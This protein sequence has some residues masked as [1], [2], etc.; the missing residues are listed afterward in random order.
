M[1]GLI[2][3]FG[4]LATGSLARFIMLALLTGA[5]ITTLVVGTTGAFFT[6][7]DAV[8]AN[9]FSTGT[10]ILTTSPTTALV[11]FSAMA[12]GD[13]D[14][15]TMTV[16]NGGSL[17]LRYAVTSATTEDTLA[18]QLDM[19]IW[20]EAAEVTVDSICD[21]T[22]PA[23]VLYSPADLG[24]V[25]GVNVIGDPATGSQTGDRTLAASAVETL[26]FRVELPSSTGNTYQNLTS[27]A[28][29]TFASEQTKNN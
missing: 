20:D 16:T 26:C 14:N 27:T 18:A 9:V 2:R 3:V 5:L 4:Q 15:G 11:S 23:T 24:S 28:T 13:V 7:S 22:A 12:P 8:G 1:F 29:L 25:S 17:Q 10:V 19:T 21:T 6:D